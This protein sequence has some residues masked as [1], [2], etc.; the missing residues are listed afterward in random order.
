MTTFR[1]ALLL[2]P[3]LA[4]F[5]SLSPTEKMFRPLTGLAAKIVP[6]LMTVCVTLP[7]PRMVPVE[8]LLTVPEALPLNSIVPPARLIE[9]W[10]MSG[11]P[12]PPGIVTSK[13]ALVLSVPSVA[14]VLL[15]KL[16]R[17]ATSV[18]L[19]A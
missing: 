6:S 11:W 4:E 17:P 15:V 9:P 19:L 12:A 14:V 18:P 10:L 1:I 3:M 8:R 7:T 13:V 5:S 2:A 16:D